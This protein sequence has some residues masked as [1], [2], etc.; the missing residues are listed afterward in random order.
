MPQQIENSIEGRLAKLPEL[1]YGIHPSTGATIVLKRG[2]KG[3]H[4]TGYGA[5]G[6]EIVNALNERMGVTRAQRTAMEFGSVLGF[7]SP[8]A[9]PDTYNSTGERR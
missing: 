5:Q 6:E 3:Y 9:D 1:C 8:A 2:Q 7:N 4:D